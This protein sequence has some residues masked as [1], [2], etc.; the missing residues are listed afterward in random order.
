LPLLEGRRLFFVGIGGAGLSA[1]AQLAH[2]WGAEVS[3]W[4]RSETPYLA[5]LGGIPVEISSR[6]APP[7]GYEVV[8][9]SAYPSVEGTPRAAFLAELVSLRRSIVVAGTHGKGTT[10]AMIAYALRESGAD[11]AWLIGAPVPQLGANAGAGEGW[12]VVEGDESDRT[13]FGLA[14]SIAVITNVEL[15]HHSEFRS[16]AE[17]EAAF[18]AWAARAET[19]VRDAPPFPGTLA[20]P[21]AH[22]RANAG[23]ALSA[24]ELAG[25][26]PARA[27]QALARF[28]GTGRRFELHELGTVTLIDDYAHHPS[29]LVATIAAAREAF[30]GRRLRGLFQPHLPSRTRHLVREFGA[31]LAGLDEVIVTEI[32]LARESPLEGVSGKLIVEALSDQGRLAR[33][34]PDLDQAARALARDARPGEVLLVLGA[35]DVDRAPALIADSIAGGRR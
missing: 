5:A 9:S 30:P 19:V 3:G 14:A 15:D 23:A 10:A 25:L 26:E 33:W 1:Y 18:A 34:I 12:L 24:L 4:D 29:E 32:Y 21:G 17:L 20:L 8:V 22:N 13:V 31:A 27:V 28:R 35:G 11:P 7:A 2:A 16:L 6:P